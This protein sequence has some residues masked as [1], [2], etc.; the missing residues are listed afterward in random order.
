MLHTQTILF[1]YLALGIL[2]RRKNILSEEALKGF[3]NFILTIALP[4]MIFSSFDIPLSRELLVNGLMVIIISIV[5]TLSMLP[6][7]KFLW[8]KAATKRQE[9]LKYGT[10]VPNAGFAGLPLLYSVFGPQAVFFASLYL[11]PQRA[12]TWPAAAMIFQNEEKKRSVKEI[13]LIPGNLAVILG[14]I[15]MF[16]PLRLPS[17]F[18]E[19]LRNVGSTA[20][21]LS[22]IAVGCML[23]EIDFKRL[24]DKQAF[25]LC[26]VRL[27]AI[28][29]GVFFILYPFR[30]D[31]MVMTVSVI[32]VAMPTGVNTVL[33]A[34]QWGGDYLFAAQCVFLSSAFSLLTIPFLTL[35]L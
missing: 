34:K 35:L 17:I 10:L 18:S 29:L 12:I 3:V 21:P 15:Y 30:P 6:L 16:L 9:V 32:L 4:F 22:I 25:L 20:V 1:L 2:I 27:V 26:V 8:R 28:P 5:V 19:V 14:M 11:A 7:G 23:S 33:F 31:F 13:V 24:Y